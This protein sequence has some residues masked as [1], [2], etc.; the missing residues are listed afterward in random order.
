MAALVWAWL[1]FGA[2]LLTGFTAAWGL[3]GLYV[4]V[5]LVSV[6][7]LPR[8]AVFREFLGLLGPRLPWVLFAALV[9]MGW[10][11]LGG[12]QPQAGGWW[13]R[14]LTPPPAPAAPPPPCPE[15]I[16]R[17]EAAGQE[18]LTRTP[19]RVGNRII[20]RPEGGPVEILLVAG[21]RAEDSFPQGLEEI[22][23]VTGPE[24]A[25]MHLRFRAPGPVPTT[26]RI[27]RSD[28]GPA[29]GWVGLSFSAVD[30]R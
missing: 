4:A 12:H 8:I 15:D 3:L 10:V 17:F 14:F 5:I 25:E 6:F 18:L 20:I 16:L 29:T 28:C 26:L 30:A 7:L 21:G 9:L 27:R 2:A 13:R 22:L 11:W 24:G 1:A 23:R 19:F